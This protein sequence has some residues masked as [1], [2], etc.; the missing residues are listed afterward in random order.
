MTL[1][2]NILLVGTGAVGSYYAGRLAQ[3]GARISTLCRSD[4]DIVKERGITVR[5]V[6]GDFH[7]KPVEVLK[8][9]DAYDLEPDYIIIA[10]KVLP[11]INIP[12]LIGKKVCPGTVIVLLQNGIDIEEPIAAAF[13]DNEII[14]AIAFIS[15]SR[16][17]FGLI[18]HKDYGRLV[19]GTY[20]SG[21][22][23]KVS[24]LAALFEQSGVRCHIDH[25]I[26]TARWK[27]LMW[28]A[29]FNP[30]SVLCGG[31]DTKEMMESEPIVTLAI[32]TMKEL[33]ILAALSGHQVNISVIDSILTDTR[34]MAPTITSMLQDYENKRPLEVEAILGNAVRLARR[35][36]VPTPRLD[37][38]YALLQLA[39]KQNRKG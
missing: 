23:D 15:V 30:L 20:P 2:S 14:S 24:R 12:S 22:S 25:D 38:L 39:D 32:D 26:I 28:N 31:A 16:P 9:I 37:T 5:S 13:P 27:K 29:P 35:T 34:A 4:Y 36:G 10:T 19:I 8:T 33:M 3:A 18:N 6:A 17:E 21:A 1:N 7:F 11:E